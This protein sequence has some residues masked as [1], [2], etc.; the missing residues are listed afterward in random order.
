M[1]EAFLNGK[2]DEVAKIVDSLKSLKKENHDKF[3]DKKD[4]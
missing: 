3:I 2:V 1:E 4:E